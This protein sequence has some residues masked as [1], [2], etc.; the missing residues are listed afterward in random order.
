MT[1]CLEA[2][3]ANASPPRRDDAPDGSEVR[4]FRVLLV[5]AADDIWRDANEGAQRRQLIVPKP[6][7]MRTYWVPR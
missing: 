3:I 1:V 4:V 2:Q 6:A 7:L 5:E